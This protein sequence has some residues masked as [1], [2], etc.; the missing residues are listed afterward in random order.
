MIECVYRRKIKQEQMATED[1]YVVM[2]VLFPAQKVPKTAG[3]WK[4][5]VQGQL[6]CC[7]GF[8]CE[9]VIFPF[10]SCSHLDLVWEVCW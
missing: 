4:S 6:H 5:G 2:G 9:G 3:N 10:S 1:C 7:P 8:S